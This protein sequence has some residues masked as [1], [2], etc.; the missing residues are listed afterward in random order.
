MCQKLQMYDLLVVI[1]FKMIEI[2]MQ[3]NYPPV[4]VWNVEGKIFFSLIASV[5]SSFDFVLLVSKC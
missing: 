4:S 3:E 1:N 5:G 2:F